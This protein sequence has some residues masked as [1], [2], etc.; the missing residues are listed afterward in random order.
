MAVSAVILCGGKDPKW[1]S[2][3]SCRAL[4][5][6]EGK[7]MFRYVVDAC[8]NAEIDDIIVVGNFLDTSMGYR[9]VLA[10]GSFIDNIAAGLE[11]A[12]CSTVL[13]A[14]CDLPALTPEA[15]ERFIRDYQAWQKLSVGYSICKAEQCERKF[16]RMRRTV[17]RLR[18]GR[19]TGG[20]LV[21]V[22]R[23][24]ILP[25]LDK[26]GRLYELRKKPLKLAKMFGWGY[27]IRLALA[28]LWPGVLG[29]ED[30]E[31]RASEILGIQVRAIEADPEVGTDIDFPDQLEAYLRS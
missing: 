23:D 2:I 11:V 31:R 26:I 24:E 6:V 30:V 29:L 28:R 4:V 10:R 3:A 12:Q 17:V 9:K 1:G 18:E 22:Q 25:K 7:P 14:T 13:I 16:P 15:V 5:P 8:W 21:L 27:F 19:F 20:N